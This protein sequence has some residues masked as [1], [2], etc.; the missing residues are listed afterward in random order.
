[1][2]RRLINPAKREIGLISK[3]ILD[4]IN[5]SI[6][7]ATHVN[8]WINSTSVIEWFSSIEDKDK[9]TFISFDIVDFYPSITEE[10]LK[11]VLAFAKKYTRI[12]KQDYEIIMHSRKSLLFNNGSP[13]AKKD[14]SSLFDVT[15]S[16]YNGAE[17]CELVG[18]YILN[19]LSRKLN[20]KNIGL[21]RDDGLAVIKNTSGATADRTRKNI[22]K[23]FSDIGLKSPSTA[24]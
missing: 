4:R 22:I 1:M 19:I 21:Y 8:Q 24:T 15:M 2:P 7:T 18:L 9:H 10:L 17:I 16:S 23:T 20:K 5:S 13:W 12:S 14:C 3:P 6:R 11:K